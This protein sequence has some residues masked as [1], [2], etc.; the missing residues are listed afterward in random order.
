MVARFEFYGSID[1]HCWQALVTCPLLDLVVELTAD[2][3]GLRLFVCA[4]ASWILLNAQISLNERLSKC[5][6]L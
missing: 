3:T 2:P 1:L 4:H 6:V 5:H